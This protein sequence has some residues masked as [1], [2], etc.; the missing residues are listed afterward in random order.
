M[1]R[2]VKIT[3]DKCGKEKQG[4]NWLQ[5]TRKPIEG[6]NDPGPEDLFLEIFIISPM[7]NGEAS[8]PRKDFCGSVCAL[9][10]LS[11]Q[12]GQCE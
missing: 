5:I 8:L 3:C 6:A 12:L 1:S 11:E 7:W 2:S 9:K 4:A 10:Y